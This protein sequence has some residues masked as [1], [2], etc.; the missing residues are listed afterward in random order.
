MLKIRVN[1][2]LLPLGRVDPIHLGVVVLGLE[3]RD[4]LSSTWPVLCAT[5][6]HRL[7]FT[8]GF[9]SELSGMLKGESREELTLV[10]LRAWEHSYV[11]SGFLVSL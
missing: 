6:E 3:C 7:L 5:M 9:T 10:G 1:F 4:S 8:A 2:P 11:I